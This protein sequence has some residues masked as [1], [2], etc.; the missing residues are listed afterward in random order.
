MVTPGLLSFDTILVDMTQVC[1]GIQMTL[2]SCFFVVLYCVFDLL[3]SCGIAFLE[4]LYWIDQ[5][6][7]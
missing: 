2:L 1:Y 3:A 6:F 5:A 7:L 4:E